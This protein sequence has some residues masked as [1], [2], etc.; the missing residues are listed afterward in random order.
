MQAGEAEEEARSSVP[1]GSTRGRYR[2]QVRVTLYPSTHTGPVQGGSQG[3]ISPA[4]AMAQLSEAP[5]ACLETGV[6]KA[7]ASYGS[8][9]GV[10]TMPSF[11]H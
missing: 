6:T 7:T 5:S 1:L 4:L 3:I 10:I 2:T 8:Y 11:P 9:C